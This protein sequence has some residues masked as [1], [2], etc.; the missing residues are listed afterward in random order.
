MPQD[1]KV[2]PETLVEEMKC[3]DRNDGGSDGGGSDGGG[4]DGGGGSDE[5]G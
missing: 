5:E 2:R 3:K 1:K 4:G